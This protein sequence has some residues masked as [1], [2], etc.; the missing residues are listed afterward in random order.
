M[1]IKMTK[2]A[3]SH[4]P[5]IG[6]IQS[7]VWRSTYNGIVPES[8]L[9]RYTPE[10]RSSIV[11]RAME[12]EN[13]EYYLVYIE[14]TPVGFLVLGMEMEG[15]PAFGDVRAI[16]LLDEF[17]SQGYGKHIMDFAVR[18]FKQLGIKQVIIWVLQENSHARSF[19]DSYGFAE[20]GKAK[21][22]NFDKKIKALRYK[23]KI[24]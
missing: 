5:V 14:K 11:E 24:K 8:Y 17:Q 7:E 16:Y 21:E 15:N 9:E 2:A 13:D 19:C 1:K 23:Y 3:V 10:S 20:E 6:K 22:I 12:S 18:R 4:A